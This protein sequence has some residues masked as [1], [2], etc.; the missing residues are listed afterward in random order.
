MTA[1]GEKLGSREL[2]Q[3]SHSLPHRWRPT[4]TDHQRR[5]ASVPG[6]DHH[7]ALVVEMD[8]IAVEQQIAQPGIVEVPI[9]H[10]ARVDMNKA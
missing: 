3:A 1:L 9:A 7:L 5:A 8:L 4:A 10:G 2:M 6:A